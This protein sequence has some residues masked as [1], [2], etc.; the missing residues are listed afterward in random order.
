MRD[1]R[2]NPHPISSPL[3]AVFPNRGLPLAAPKSLG[4]L[5][6]SKRDNRFIDVC[7]FTV[8]ELVFKSMVSRVRMIQL[9]QYIDAEGTTH[10]GLL[11]HKPEGFYGDETLYHDRIPEEHPGYY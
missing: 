1:R 3:I 6:P 7:E 4:P 8:Y 9:S 5:P 2:P 11:E 10:S